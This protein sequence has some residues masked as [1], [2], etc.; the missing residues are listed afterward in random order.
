[1]A[2]YWKPAV[3]TTILGYSGGELEVSLE[4]G[5]PSLEVRLPGRHEVNSQWAWALKFDG[6]MQHR[7]RMIP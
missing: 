7:R 3:K 5:Q 4:A 1:M 6:V 2:R